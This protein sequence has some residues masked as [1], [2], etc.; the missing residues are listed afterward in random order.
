MSEQSTKP[1]G[2][3]SIWLIF[4]L[5]VS[6]AINTF[7]IGAMVGGRASTER[8][9]DWI[10]RH[11]GMEHGDRFGE[12]RPGG[13]FDPRDLIAVLPESARADAIAVLED[14]GPAIREMMR[15]S[16]EA[17]FASLE[18]MRASP[19][20]AAALDAAFAESRQADM[21]LLVA[22]HEAMGE[23]VTDLTPEERAHMIEEL[24]ERVPG[25]HH[26]D[27]SRRDRGERRRSWRDRERDRD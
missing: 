27:R 14:Q 8:W 12:G 5:V 23:I 2:G 7:F 24:D 13:M 15:A 10:S 4:G 1:S 3:T 19:F 20:D 18:A 9:T 26:R 6:L 17:R 21:A 22:L 11:G 16:G 25:Y